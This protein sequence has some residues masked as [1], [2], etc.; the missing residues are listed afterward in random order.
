MGLLQLLIDAWAGTTCFALA[1][2]KGIFTG[3]VRLE[4]IRNER[5]RQ[6][7]QEYLRVGETSLDGINRANH[8]IMS[9]YR[10]RQQGAPMPW[11]QTSVQMR[12]PPQVEQAWRR[13]SREANQL[14][15]RLR[16]RTG[17]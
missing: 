16:N 12:A 14:I 10:A 15:R 4:M 17:R 6:F 2:Q 13:L 11:K 7:M 5:F 8:Q 3:A 9:F 1:R